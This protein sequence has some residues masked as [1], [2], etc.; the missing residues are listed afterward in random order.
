MSSGIKRLKQ[1]LL[2]GY[3]DVLVC[4]KTTTEIMKEMQAWIDKKR[5][6]MPLDVDDS[7]EQEG[8]DQDDEVQEVVAVGQQ[9]SQA[10]CTGPRATKESTPSSGT[11]SKK[12][13]AA[14]FFKPAPTKQLK[15]APLL[16]KSLEELV[17]LR[18]APG[19]KQLSL[20]RSGKSDAE[21]NVAVKYICKFLYD[22]AIAFNVVNSRSFEEMVEA[23]GQYGH[24]LKPPSYH[25]ASDKYI[26]EAINDLSDMRKKHELAWKTYGCTLMSDAWSDRKQRHLVNFLVNSPEG[27]FFLGSVNASSETHDVAYLAG[28]LGQKIEEIDR[29]KDW[30]VKAKRVT[31]FVYRH[32]KLLDK[33]REYTCG[34]E[35]VRPAATRFATTFYTLQSMHKNKEALRKLFVSDFWTKNK[36]A[37]TE[38]GKHVYEVVMSMT[39]WNVVEDCIR[40]SH[41]VLIV[42]RLVDGDENPAMPQLT[43]AME[44]CKNKL[45]ESF[46]RKPPL[47]EKLMQI[48]RKRWDDQM[49][50]KLHGAALFL[51]PGRFFDIME[52]DPDYAQTLRMTFNQVVTK[53]MDGDEEMIATI[54]V[55]ADDYQ[56]VRGD[57][58]DTKIAINGRKR[59]S[60]LDWWK[61]NGG[62]QALPLTKVARRIVGLCTSASACERNWSTFERIHSKKRNKLGHPKLDDLSYISFNSKIQERFARLHHEGNKV[63]P[64]FLEEFQW[65]NEW[66]DKDAEV[67]QRVHEE[68]DLTWDQVD[69]AATTSLSLVRR[70]QTRGG[71]GV[72]SGGNFYTRRAPDIVDELDQDPFTCDDEDVDDDV[73]GADG[74]QSQP[75]GG[76]DNEAD[77]DNSDAL[78]YDD[79]DV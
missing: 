25:E 29:F 6:K 46:S 16:L 60:P 37:K 45:N 12:R 24:G 76:E 73:V 40:A 59:K 27:T 4:E 64:L 2:G 30:I 72:P 56:Q 58:F 18:H 44:I 23:I 57:C 48:F 55:L 75:K 74:P 32:L 3:G 35:L 8:G 17:R 15:I 54:D 41:P 69:A 7:E 68:D 21:R 61:S 26:K 14:A 31:T 10:S 67:V 5:R 9:A 51:N 42:L 20:Y 50:Q 70:N 77:G 78:E 49:M 33:M 43:A 71:H 19:A 1:H 22:N 34:N 13:A 65:D 38:T 47:L 36:L 11:A 66:V 79:H 52:N 62:G 63:N 39:F 53:M 28:L